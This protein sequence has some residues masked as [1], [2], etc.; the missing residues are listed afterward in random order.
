MIRSAVLAVTNRA[1]TRKLITDTKAGKAVAHRFV[2]GT[3]LDEAVAVATD[4]NGSGLKVSMDYLGEHVTTVEEATAATASYLACIDRI[5]V[6]G[7]D[8]N[9]SVKLTQLG[10]GLDD[11]MAGENLDRLAVAA[12]GV[13]TSVT[14]DM[15]ESEH[16]EMT[17]SLYETVQKRHGNLGIALQSY[18]RRTPDDLARIMPLGG[19]IRLCKG[20]YAEPAEIAHQSGSHVDGAYDHLTGVL[21][22]NPGVKPAIATHDD[23]RI[24]CALRHAGTR[25]APWEFQMLYGVRRDRQ[26]DLV[27]AGHS[28]RIYVPYGEA[29]YPYLTRRLAERPANLTF[30]ARA[31]VGR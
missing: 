31:L 21:M 23:A 27:A 26:L 15:E 13:G 5:G 14:V 2:A 29:W 6:E 28:M 20:A 8:A 18:L 1:A 25:T 12:L 17:I 3:E 19:H 10:M 16:T 24:E 7:L 11:A 22:S 9:V 4:L 30:F